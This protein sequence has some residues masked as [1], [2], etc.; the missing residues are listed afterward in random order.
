[1]SRPVCFG[2]VSLG[3][4]TIC[5][6][7]RPAIFKP[8]CVRTVGAGRRHFDLGTMTVGF[9]ADRD[10]L[11]FGKR[12]RETMFPESQFKIIQAT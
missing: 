5:S 12:E 2:T 10:E 9:E 11:D 4:L 6:G 7:R 8:H 1:M 3:P